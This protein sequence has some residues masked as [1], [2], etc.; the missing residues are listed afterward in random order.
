MKRF[1]RPL[2]PYLRPQ[3]TRAYGQYGEDLV[4][5]NALMPSRN[6]FYVDVGAYDP[7]DASN[8]YKLYKRGWRGITIEPNPQAAWK[9]RLLRGRDTH[10]TVGVSST[11]ST[12]N[13]HQFEIGMLNTMDEA[14]AK[15]LAESGYAT[16]GVR[17]VRCD[18][19][20]TLLEE[21]AGGRQI[22][23]LNVDCEGDDLGVLATIDYSTWRPTV[24]LMEDLE[25]YYTMD[26]A[27]EASAAVK[28]MRER[29]YVPIARL[30][31]TL[32]FVARDWRALNARS[33]AYREEAI[34]PGLLPE[35]LA[36]PTP[37]SA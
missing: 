24:V 30:V 5:F 33:K 4:V 21:N 16:R 10:L 1:A 28:F 7:V 15:A 36:S 22:D 29:D 6:G 13:Y 9:F 20:D 2:K 11:P 8:T 3:G 32:V 34:Y 26:R 17:E 25:G 23:L 14:R 12:L 18:R 35:P 19:L 27:G 37:A 31:F